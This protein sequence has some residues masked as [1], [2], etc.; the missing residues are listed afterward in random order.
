MK[1]L[2]AAA[3]LLTSSLFAST[4]TLTFV[5]YP[6]GAAAPYDFTL[7]GNP[8][9]WICDTDFRTISPGDTWTATE[10]KVGQGPLGTDLEQRTIAELM[11]EEFAAPAG[12]Q[13][14]ADLQYAQWSILL[15]TNVLTAAQSSDLSA[16]TL[17]A[18]NHPDA[19]FSNIVFDDNPGP[20]QDGGHEVPE[21][22]SLAL[23][24][25]GLIGLGALARRKLTA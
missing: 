12:S 19:Y 9:K 4:V 6:D 10:D 1:S 5:A 13:Q 18:S 11:L 8:I 23:L 15:P 14:Q 17:F 21:P 7:N 25:S 16:A 20:F 22:S 2:L 3:L 24:G